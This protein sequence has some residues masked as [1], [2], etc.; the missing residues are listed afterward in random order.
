MNL[1]IRS[2]HLESH[3]LEEVG[4]TVVF[5]RFTSRARVNPHTDGGRLRIVLLGGNG[6]A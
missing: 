4:C 1:R 2:T 5:G 3:V 6:E